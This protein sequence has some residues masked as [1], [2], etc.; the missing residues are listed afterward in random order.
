MRTCT[1]TAVIL[2]TAA[3]HLAAG[4]SLVVVTG[5]L[6]VAASYAYSQQHHDGAWIL[7]DVGL[8]S[9]RYGT[10]RPARMFSLTMPD[11]ARIDPPDQRQFRAGLDE[12]Q[13]MYSRAATMQLSPWLAIPECRVHAFIGWSLVRGG[14]YHIDQCQNWRL[15]GNGG[16]DW[17]ASVGPTTAGGASLFFQSPTGVWP[18]GEY[19]L[20]VDGP[21]DLEARLPIRLQ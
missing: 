6:T 3:V 9:S 19:T 5:D 18:A 21:G 10:I 8:Q 15:W 1:L 14:G 17:T 16:I 11:G 4:Q 13:A 2:S 20:M 7:I 12:I